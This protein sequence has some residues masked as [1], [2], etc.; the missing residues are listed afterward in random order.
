MSLFDE[1]QWLWLILLIGVMGLAMRTIIRRLSHRRAQR[2]GLASTRPAT[3]VSNSANE[4]RRA[5]GS[6]ASAT[7]T[8]ANGNV[9]SGELN[10]A[11]L[12]HGVGAYQYKVTRGSLLQYTPTQLGTRRQ[13]L[14]RIF[15]S[16]RNQNAQ[17]GALLARL[18]AHPLW[19][20]IDALALNDAAAFVGYA[21]QFK[22]GFQHGVG[23]EFT[24]NDQAYEGAFRDGKRHGFGVLVYA[25]GD[26]G[27]YVGQ[28][29]NDKK[30]DD[31]GTFI[32]GPKIDPPSVLPQFALNSC[33]FVGPF[34]NGL[35][36]GRG[37]LRKPDGTEIAIEFQQGKV[38]STATAPVPATSPQ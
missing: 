36:H 33:V 18:F 32:F 25:A 7:L 34:R 31:A 4:S 16:H 35:R 12:F 9:Y 38:V 37:T 3:H 15:Q 27:V 5:D 2:L 10:A 8:F 20:S 14:L 19:R 6:L 21:G 30:H 13:A 17:C 29:L 23:R 24:E 28:F 26:Q 1:H 22:D 11:Q